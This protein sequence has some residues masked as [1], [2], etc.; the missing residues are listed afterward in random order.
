MIVRVFAIGTLHHCMSPVYKGVEMLHHCPDCTMQ[1]SDQ[2]MCH[3]SCHH[4][5][6][7]PYPG[8]I[9]LCH[10]CQTAVR[11]AAGRVQWSQDKPHPR[12]TGKIRWCSEQ[13]C[14]Q[15]WP[16]CPF[17]AT[18]VLVD[19]AIINIA[20]NRTMH[21]SIVAC[22]LLAVAAP[23]ASQMTAQRK[24]DDTGDARVQGS[25]CGSG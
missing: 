20:H 13:I 2:V 19:I 4:Q 12:C 21:C 3:S 14:N 8:C 25:C 23:A 15:C 17:S 16:K 1:A 10:L 24:T 6:Y 5:G 22:F 11:P 7:V 9:T 18:P